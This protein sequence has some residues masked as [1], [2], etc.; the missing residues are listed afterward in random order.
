MYIQKLTKFLYIYVVA[1]TKLVKNSRQYCYCLKVFETEVERYLIQYFI[2]IYL[3][4]FISTNSF[5]ELRTQLKLRFLCLFHSVKLYI[6]I[7]E[8]LYQI[9]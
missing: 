4:I 3:F 7:I 8:T 6:F 2:K 9:K 1:L 5:G